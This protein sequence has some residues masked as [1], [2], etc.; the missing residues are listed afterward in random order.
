MPTLLYDIEHAKET[1]G[2]G[3]I[4]PI[5]LDVTITNVSYRGAYVN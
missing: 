1:H 3:T 2:I 5:L 4:Y